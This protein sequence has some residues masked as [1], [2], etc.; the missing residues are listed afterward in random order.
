[1]RLEDTQ[2]I[3]TDTTTEDWF[4]AYWASGLQAQQRRYWFLV[5][6]GTVQSRN[7][8]LET[9]INIYMAIF[10]VLTTSQPTIPSSFS[11]T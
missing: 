9:G 3:S 11:H 8:P 1:M 7:T 5:S 10:S 6:Y 4:P 2:A